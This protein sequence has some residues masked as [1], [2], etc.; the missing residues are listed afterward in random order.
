MDRL[1]QCGHKIA[2]TGG[3]L[4]VVVVDVFMKDCLELLSP[5]CVEDYDITCSQAY[6]HPVLTG[7]VGNAE[8]L[9]LPSW[10]RVMLRI[11]AILAKATRE[12]VLLRALSTDMPPIQRVSHGPGHAHH[13]SGRGH[14]HG[15]FAVH[16]ACAVPR[17]RCCYSHLVAD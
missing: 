17:K 1:V 3:K 9:M 11:M 13:L 2:P 7:V 8:D 6:Q 16:G 12:T 14:L 10:H 4:E 5:M 15:P